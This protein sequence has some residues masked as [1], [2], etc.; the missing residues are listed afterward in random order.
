MQRRRFLTGAS[1]LSLGGSIGRGLIGKGSVGLLA[2]SGG[3]LA[4]CTGRQPWDQFTTSID[5][6]GMTQGHKIRDFVKDNPAPMGLQIPTHHVKTCI[7][8]SGV[9]GLSA[10]WTLHQA[11]DH[12]QLVLAGPELHG[13]AA[14]LSLG[15]KRC[16]TG[17]HYLPLPSRESGHVRHILAKMGVLQEGID[18]DRPRYDESIVVHSPADRLLKDGQWQSGLPITAIADADGNAQ[19]ARFTQLIANMSSRKGADGKR[20][21][22][23]PIVLSSNDPQWLALD[24]F[25]FE[26]WLTRE[27]FTSPTLRWYLDYCCRDEFGSGLKNVSAWAGLHYFC[28]RSGH[29]SNAED[30]AVLTWP[31]GLSPITQFL[32]SE[33]TARGQLSSASA[34]HIQRSA[35]GI[36]PYVDV[37]ALQWDAQGKP[38][39]MMIRAQ[40]VIVATPLFVT[41]R[42]DPEIKL[43]FK[44]LAQLL[45]PMS[46]WLMGNFQFARPLAELIGQSLSWD[47]VVYQSKGLGYVNADHQAVRVDQS[48]GSILTTYCALADHQAE[49]PGK[50]SLQWLAQAVPEQ[51]LAMASQD[52]V[53]AYGERFWQHLVHAHITVRGH[54]MASPQPG[55]LSNHLIHQLRNETGTVTYAHADLSGYSVFEEAAWWGVRAARLT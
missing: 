13:N 19:N 46:S 33:A 29:A 7:V 8:G 35:A 17:A 27:R 54:A 1:T 24:A 43:A 3:L 55:F 36:K 14:A 11:G 34:I 51:L 40:R 42:I 2:G 5:Y 47:N 12:N 50:Q 39:P 15:G 44:N 16:P 38:S 49:Q 41:A 37:H 52:L 20:I 48:L 25:T 30:G 18:T 10:S 6:P 4:G 32:A 22:V 26:A 45:P 21:F 28:S 53:A 9:A 31:D 23:V